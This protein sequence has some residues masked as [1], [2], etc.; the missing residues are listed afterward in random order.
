MQLSNDAKFDSIS[1]YSFPQK[2]QREILKNSMRNQFLIPYTHSLWGDTL[3]RSIAYTIII[4]III[5]VDGN[6]TG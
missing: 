2:E 4:I 3:V 5:I 6:V 1:T